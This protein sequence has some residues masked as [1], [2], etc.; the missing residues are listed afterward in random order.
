MLF[1]ASDGTTGAEL[2]RS[3]GTSAGTVQVKDIWAGTNG[4]APAGFAAINGVLYFSADDGYTGTE[5]WSSKGM[6]GD[7]VLVA[8]IFGGLTT[9]PSPVPNSSDPG[10]FLSFA[11]NVL[12]PATAGPS[13]NVELFRYTGNGSPGPATMVKKINPSTTN[14]SYP[15]SLTVA[16]GKL[17]FIANDGTHGDQLWVTT[18]GTAAGTTSL[19]QAS[20][21]VDALKTSEL[22]AFGQ[23]VYFA[24]ADGTGRRQLWASD[25]TVAGTA[26]SDVINPSGDGDPD[27]FAVVGTTLYF[28]GTDAS[29]DRELWG[30][31]GTSAAARIANVDPKG[32][33]SPDTLTPSGNLLFF[34]ADD[35]THGR[36]LCVTSGT[37][38]GTSCFD[39]WQ[40]PRGSAVSSIASVAPG[41][42]VFAASD[43]THGVELWQSDGTATGTVMVDDIAPGPSSSNPAAL[44]YS[45]ALF[46]AFFQAD[47]G[48]KGVELRTISLPS[49]GP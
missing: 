33:S 4:S 47:D 6:V 29:G 26:L 27:G 15:R 39:I 22:V 48:Q 45:T 46:R 25:G 43:G 9:G 36:E 12:F 28:A 17:F 7:P 2:W 38:A 24:S 1:G 8:D 11:G 3:D 18:D 13:T 32:S 30:K 40:G 31:A 42:V 14:G 37:Q 41:R 44:V 10:P 19:M 21:P 16:A 20:Q 5:L 23:G 49:L 35:G 34:A